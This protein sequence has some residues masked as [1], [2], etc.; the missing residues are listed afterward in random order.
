MKIEFEVPNYKDAAEDIMRIVRGGL[1][2]A[3]EQ[4]EK[5]IDPKVQ[6]ELIEDAI[7]HAL[8]SA[9]RD[10]IMSIANVSDTISDEADYECF[11]KTF[12]FDD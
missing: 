2:E 7:K 6:V 9:Y 12:G 1:C 4:P 11:G 10:G 3:Y 8:I 5:R